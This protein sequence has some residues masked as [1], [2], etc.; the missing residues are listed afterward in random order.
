MF[1][2]YLVYLFQLFFVN[3]IFALLI[4]TVLNNKNTKDK[5]IL[6]FASLGISPIFTSLVI[7]YLLLLIPHKTSLFYL[8]IITGFYLLIYL[9]KFKEISSAIKTIK[10]IIL[11][12]DKYLL[13]IILLFIVVWQIIIVTIPIL[14]HDTFEYATQGKIFFINKSIIYQERQFDSATNF[15]YVGLHGFGYPL[16]GTVE[17]FF[18]DIFLTQKDYYL[19][20]ISGYYWILIV[21]LQYYLLSKKNKI[22][23]ILATITLITSFGFTI[24]F[25]FYHLDT[26]RI[27]LLMLSTIY[28][29]KSIDS[30]NNLNLV[31][32]GITTGL[33]AFSH[34]LNCIIGLIQ[35]LTFLIFQKY[36]KQ[37]I[38]KT[39]YITILFILFGG[40]HYILDTF[41][42]T[43]WI[44]K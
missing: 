9:I 34:S 35:I 3:G 22:L 30:N 8:L 6:L 41:W 32:F 12:I 15:F 11:N 17:R 37:K 14:S 29:L 33:S 18:N 1:F 4:F 26:L 16:F 31:L 38:Y 36:F 5:V 42:G 44:I 43:G 10:N 19:R 39:I 13:S 23:A 28:L 27:F 20:S 2:K 40:I 24:M 25:A 7:Y 21:L